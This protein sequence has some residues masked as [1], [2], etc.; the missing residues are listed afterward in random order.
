M[1]ERNLA[2]QKA[3]FFGLLTA[4]CEAEF[5]LTPPFPQLISTLQAVSI[6]VNFSLLTLLPARFLHC[7][8]IHISLTLDHVCGY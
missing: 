2:E 3:F 1:L 4:D 6:L 5:T 7:S 8:A